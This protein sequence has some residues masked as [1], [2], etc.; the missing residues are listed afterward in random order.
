MNQ[1]IDKLI[2]GM[3]S[4]RYSRWRNIA[5]SIL[6]VVLCTLMVG[7]YWY[8]YFTKPLLECYGG[9]LFFSGVWLISEY[10]LIAYLYWYNN[11]PRFARTNIKMLIALS[12]IWFGRF[13]YLISLCGSSNCRELACHF[14][15]A[16]QAKS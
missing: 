8:L 2:S 15:S 9:Y 6:L 5:S 4:T 7:C 11:I 10:V 14:L 16:H 3:L 1:K 13:I 12:N